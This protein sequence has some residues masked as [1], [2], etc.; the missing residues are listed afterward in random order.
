MMIVN[1]NK[2]LTVATLVGIAHIVCGIA[3]IYQP[4][5][6]VV[7]Q[8]NGIHEIITSFGYPPVFGG[9]T[10]LIV[11]IMAVYA[12]RADFAESVALLL[13]QQFLLCLQIWSIT[14]VLSTGQYPDG[15]VPAGGP[16]FILTD[17]IWAWILTVSHSVWLAAYIYQGLRGKRNGAVS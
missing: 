14:V 17:Q 2:T 11:G 12:G 9:Y 3:A 6:L 16:W 1:A 15:H 10:L 5:T 4:G 8:L 7:T 13:P